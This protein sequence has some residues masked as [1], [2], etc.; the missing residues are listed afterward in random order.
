MEIINESDTLYRFRFKSPGMSDKLAHFVIT[1]D[2]NKMRMFLIQH[3]FDL[4]KAIIENAPRKE[5]DGDGIFMLEEYIL[6]SNYSDKIYKIMSNE[7]II[8]DCA[9]AVGSIMSNSLVFGADVIRDDLPIMK[10]ISELV[11]QLDHVYVLDHT[12]C[13]A[14]GNPYSSAYDQYTK[15]GFPN[16]D[17]YCTDKLTMT[18]EPSEYDDNEIYNSIS[19][20]VGKGFPLPFTIEMYV[21]YFAELLTDKYN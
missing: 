15:T 2:L 20:N 11:N 13:D 12:L 5:H 4:S 8:Y 17:T 21:S 7:K 19:N 16:P 9:Q 10:A 3:N 1:D 18:K 14:N 6:K